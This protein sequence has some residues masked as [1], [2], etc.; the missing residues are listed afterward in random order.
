MISKQQMNKLKYKRFNM[1]VAD[2]LIQ[3]NYDYYFSAN[4]LFRSLI[5][6]LSIY[7]YHN[8]LYFNECDFFLRC[9]KLRMR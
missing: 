7:K 4:I 3:I 5:Y 1:W 8:S 2:D 6:S 9:I